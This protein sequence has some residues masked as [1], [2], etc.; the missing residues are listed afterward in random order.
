MQIVPGTYDACIAYVGNQ[1]GVAL[2]A[3]TRTCTFVCFGAHGTCM[4]YMGNSLKLFG[5]A[6]RWDRGVRW[7]CDMGLKSQKQFVQGS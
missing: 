4:A 6:I 2:R 7:G 1:K 3:P 5:E